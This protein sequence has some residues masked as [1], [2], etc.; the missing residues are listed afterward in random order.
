VN[1]WGQVVGQADTK[2]PDPNG[3]DFCGSKALGLTQSGNTCVPFLWQQGSMIALPRLRNSDG[4]E[5]SNGIALQV[6]D[7]GIAT[8]TAENGELDSTCPGASVS[9]QRIEFK[10]VIWTRPFPWSEVHV[11][12]L[13]TFDDEPDGVAFAMNN[14]G[15]VV[16]STGTCG[17]FNSTEPVNLISL[18]AVL[19]QNGKAI[20]LG[21][22]GGDGKAFG[23]FATG[24]NDYGQ[25]VG[26]SDTVGDKSFHA[27]LWQQGHITDLGTLKGDSYSHGTAI[28]NNG[29]AL[30][31][32]LDANFNPRAV[33]WR[34]GT[35]TDMNTL[36]PADS[37]LKLQSACS[38]NDKG[39]IIGFAALKSNPNE[40]HAY[41]AKPVVSS[42]DGD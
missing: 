12:E 30:G 28:G 31:V 22:L 16:G 1:T 10:P 23:I 24:L 34:N 26:T 27:F 3:E 2:T 32:S 37:T 7:F 13:H 19:W 17:P 41:L 9:A 33:L 36:V 14:L 40:S 25:V 8:G 15:Q 39:E 35:A 20:D 11:H 42:E 18:H 4:K 5:G 38:I 29:L 6:N 21:N